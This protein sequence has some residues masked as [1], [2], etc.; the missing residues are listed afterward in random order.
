MD[1]PDSK[2]ILIAATDP[3]IIYLL[4]RYAEASGFQT[5]HCGFG[6]GLIKLAK[7]VNPVLVVLQIE[8]PESTW[9]QSLIMLKA[10]PVTERIPI[11][12]YSCFDEMICHQVDGFTSILQKSVL[13]GDFLTALERAGVRTR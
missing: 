2:T 4:Q 6:D 8:P 3:N 9:Q 12:A 1:N 13:Y 5:A 10:E 11:I 7:Q